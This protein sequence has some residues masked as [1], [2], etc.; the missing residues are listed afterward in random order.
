MRMSIQQRLWMSSGLMLVVLAVA[1]GTGWYFAGGVS[2][3]VERTVSHDV[4]QSQHALKATERLAAALES[5]RSFLLERRLQDA[6]AV[7]EMLNESIEHLKH[8]G[9][10]PQ[11]LELAQRYQTLFKQLVDLRTQRG[12]T[13][14]QGLEGELRKA[15]HGIEKAVEEQ[16]RPELTIL[17]LLCRRH[18]K[19]YLLRGEHRYLDDI[20]RRISEF[21]EQMIKAG[22]SPELQSALRAQWRAYYESVEAIV[23]IDEKIAEVTEELETIAVALNRRAHE[24]DA[25]ATH[26]I[27]EDTTEVTAQLRRLQWVMMGA[28]AG[29]MVIGS[30]LS[31]MTNRTISGSVERAAETLAGGA[32]QT[33]SAARQVSQAAQ[34]LAEGCSEQAASIEETSSSLDEVSG[35]TR[36]NADA[37]ERAAGLAQTAQ[38]AA[39]QGESAMQRMST[40][41]TDIQTNATE[42]AKILKVIDEIAFQTN[43]LALNAAVEAARAGEAGK[44]FA[45]V[46]EEV[47]NLAMRSA[48]AAKNTAEMIDRSVQGAQTGVSIAQEV[49]AALKQIAGSSVELSSLIAEIAAASKEQAEGVAQVNM[50]AAQLQ[51]ATQSNAAHAEESAAAAEEL[52]S[53]ATEATA[54]VNELLALVGRPPIGVAPAAVHTMRTERIP[55]DPRPI[56]ADPHA[57]RRAA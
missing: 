11:A 15:V 47:R 30:L 54:R 34:S 3:T 28:L 50:A 4:P 35:M 2:K 9:S 40:A 49:G 53:Q 38:G 26:T 39:T 6:A 43:L 55:T 42:T 5:E 8:A 56:F 1:T 46:A 41:I 31:W 27:E 32:E 51:K 29:G 7:H 10:D 14:E 18:E 33:A 23:T 48:E 16:Q 45:V 22:F 52:A 19:D 44:G 37:A 21:D 25:A 12:L 57:E 17:L 20:A 13:Q 24:I 36:R